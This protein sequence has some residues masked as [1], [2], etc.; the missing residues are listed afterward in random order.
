MPSKAHIAI[1]PSRIF[2]SLDA[3]AEIEVLNQTD[4]RVDAI[5]EPHG[6]V[7]AL[8]SRVRLGET[9]IV[10]SGDQNG[11]DDHFWQFAEQADLLVMNQVIVEDANDRM[12]SRLA[13]PSVIGQGAARAGVDRMLLTHLMQRS[14]SP[15]QT[16][17]LIRESFDGEIVFAE[18]LMCV[19]LDPVD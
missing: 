7:P 15:E 3:E 16:R 11:R 8:A 18:D 10:F 2:Q 1:W 14:G 12:L 6:A 9:A 19:P 4:L 13:P 5:G 17:Q